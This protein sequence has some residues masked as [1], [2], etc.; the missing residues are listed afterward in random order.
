MYLRRLLWYCGRY[1]RFALRD[2]FKS[3]L[4]WA[5][6][7]GVGALG[8][9]VE[10][11]R[12]HVTFAE[13]WQGVVLGAFVYTIIAWIVIFFFRLLFLAPLQVWREG[14]WYD[15]KF[16]YHE[17]KRAFVAYVSPTENKKVHHFKFSD[18]PPAAMISYK[19][20]TE[21]PHLIVVDVGAHPKQIEFSSGYPHGGG[22]MRVNRRRD[23]YVA[24]TIRENTDPMSVRIYVIGWEW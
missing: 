5:S 2:S 6:I 12:L 13:G 18:A 9:F 21:W 19:I 17:P 4:N 1:L 15:G 11:Q 8:A 3:A 23:M 16:V 22:S 7:L 14:K 20:E 10:W 24:I